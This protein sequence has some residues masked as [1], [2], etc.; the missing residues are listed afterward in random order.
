LFSPKFTIPDEKLLQKINQTNTLRAEIQAYPFLSITADCRHS[1]VHPG[2][3]GPG[4]AFTD[5][6]PYG[7]GR[8]KEEFFY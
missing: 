2:C 1:K 3:P 7:I 4:K 8:D 5:L 6:V